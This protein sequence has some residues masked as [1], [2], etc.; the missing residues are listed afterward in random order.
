MVRN[1]AG[2]LLEVGAGRRLSATMP[3]LLAQRDR[4]AAGPTAPAHGL[5]LERVFYAV[6]PFAGGEMDASHRDS[7]GK[8]TFSG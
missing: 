7:K 6:D 5:T 3:A 1:L 8:G 4:S 2:T